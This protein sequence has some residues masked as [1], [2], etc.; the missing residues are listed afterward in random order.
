M[1]RD[2]TTS[3]EVVRMTKGIHDAIIIGLRIDAAV[4]AGSELVASGKWE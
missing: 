1:R 3:N 2:S 4:G